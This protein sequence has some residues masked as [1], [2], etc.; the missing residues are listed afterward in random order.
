M[1]YE[2]SMDSVIAKTLGK[3]KEKLN[4]VSPSLLV[5]QSDW[6][7]E[8]SS[9]NQ[10]AVVYA[11]GEIVDGG[12]S[13]TINYEKLVPVITDLADNDKVKGMV[14][15]VNSPG[16]AVFGDEQIGEALDYFQSKGKTLAVSMGDYA[17]PGGYWISCCAD[18]ILP[19]LS[20][21]PVL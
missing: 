10:V 16:G 4:F 19:I 18:R 14:L 9:K 13:S 3:D 21:S 12:S 7:S 6:G 11:T 17:A 5:G 15:R 2:R 1:Y 20:P 8:Y